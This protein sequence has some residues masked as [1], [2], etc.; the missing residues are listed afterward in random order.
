MSKHKV[1]EW[2][3]DY[4]GKIIRNDAE[5]EEVDNHHMEI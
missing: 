4:K 2:Y 3:I 5:M 1:C